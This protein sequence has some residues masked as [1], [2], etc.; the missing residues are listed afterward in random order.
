[1]LNSLIRFFT[2]VRLTVVCLALAVVLVFVGTLA[3][4]EQGL[5]EAQSRYFKSFFVTWAVPGTD[6]RIP[7]YPGGYLL[8]SVLVINLIAS[9]VRRYPFK[10][11]N[12]GLLMIHS[13]LVLLLVGQLVT[14]VF[15][16]EGAMRLE[17]GETRNYSE[18]FHATELVIVDTTD[19][20]FDRVVSVPADWLEP[21]ATFDLPES[22]FSLRVRRFW[23]N[24][25][26][27]SRP[28]PGSEESGAT[29]GGGK[30]RHVVAHPITAKMDERNMPA[31]TIELTGSASLGS[32]LVS[33]LLVPQTFSHDGRTYQIALRPKRHYKP[34]SLTLLDLRHDVYKGTTIPRNFSSR[35]RIQDPQSGEDREV[36]IYMNNP[37]RY[38][39]FTYY[40]YQMAPRDAEI[41]SSTLQVVRNPGWLTPYLGCLLVG[42]GLT[43]HF[44]IH[45]VSFLKKRRA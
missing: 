14:D 37:L 8:G 10:L 3:Q 38:A 41:K 39:G 29:E 45:L 34:Y 31:A 20:K 35:V 23:P 40:Q 18:D 44:M 21:G 32:W 36:L 42:F 27:V 16:V 9:Y 12:T 13:G 5:Y 26:I 30:G 33:G 7:V 28:A 24:A 2:S 25:D 19:P 43:L 11:R 6:W 22:P 17:P 15:S 1:M 4:V